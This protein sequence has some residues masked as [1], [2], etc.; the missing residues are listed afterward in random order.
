MLDRLALR[1]AV[2]TRRGLNRLARRSWRAGE[3]L[4]AAGFDSPRSEEFRRG[5]DAAFGARS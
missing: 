3:L 1:L 2:L 4:N 5:I